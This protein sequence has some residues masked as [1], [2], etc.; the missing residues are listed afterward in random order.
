MRIKRVD[1]LYKSTYYRA[2]NK[3]S[4]KQP[5]R[6][7]RLINHGFEKGSFKH[8]GLEGLTMDIYVKTAMDLDGDDISPNKVYKGFKFPDYI[9]EIDDDYM[10]LDLESNFM[11]DNYGEDNNIQIL[12]SIVLN[13]EGPKIVLHSKNNK[14][15]SRK[16]ANNF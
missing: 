8:K 4:A 11:L 6:G 5:E 15:S 14:F 10:I 2:G 7:R 12:V 9:T 16:S 3:I 13:E 1:E